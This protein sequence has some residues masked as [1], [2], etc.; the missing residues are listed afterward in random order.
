[1][2]TDTK[3]KYIE[4]IGRRKEAVARVRITPSSK[5]T[6]IVNEKEIEEYFPLTSHQLEAKKPLATATPEAKFTV[7]VLVKGG[8]I[9]SQ[10]DSISLGLARA[11]VV[12]DPEL[13]KNLKTAGLLT[14]DARVK[15]RKKFGLK[16]ARK[17]PQWSK[18]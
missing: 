14:R 7:S 6:F 5:A 4:A 8:G 11:L 16:K 2:A 13:K 3:N 18:R 10:A 15:E 12:A 17:S 1:M 9:A